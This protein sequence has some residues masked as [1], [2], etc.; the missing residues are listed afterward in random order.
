MLVAPHHAHSAT[1]CDGVM[2]H[3]AMRVAARAAFPFETAVA[4][5]YVDVSSF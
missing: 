3:H 4:L 5:F 1:C 2:P